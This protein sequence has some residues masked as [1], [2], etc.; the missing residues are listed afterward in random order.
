M[1]AEKSNTFFL[2]LFFILSLST[3]TLVAQN[4]SSLTLNASYVG[5][6]VANF[7]GGIKTGTTYLGL[8]NMK[9]A[10]D[11]EKA[12]WWKGGLF[13][14]NA[15]NTHGG[16]PTANLVGDYQAFSNIE[17]GNH[18]FM[19]ELWYKEQL[20]NFALTAG[21][22]DLNVDFAA[23]ESGILF[24]NSSF[25]IH[26]S[27]G[28]NIP[29]PIFPLTAL[30]VTLQWQLH[31]NLL[32]KVALFDGTPDEFTNNP[33]NLRW[34]LGRGDGYLGISEWQLSGSLLKGQEGTY[35]LGMY[36]HSHNDDITGKVN[37]YGF[38]LIGDQQIVKTGNGNVSLFSQIGVSPK[39]NVNNFFI[40]FGTNWKAPFATR[41]KDV[42][43]IAFAYA[44]MHD[45]GGIGGEVAIET[46]YKFHVNEHIYLRPDF[47][48]II[49]PAGTDKKLPNA[50]VG[51]MRF[52]IEF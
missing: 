51:T 50:F 39:K 19:Y 8:A 38:Y 17:A 43:G 12:G 29:S 24:S 22:Q 45:N 34:K 42:C 9:M 41:P 2:T 28:T 33:Y 14:V 11:L 25:G 48:Y 32:W 20:G 31:P 46:T 23:T 13:F 10:F 40:S 44:A 26:S 36:S 27:I 16:E 52:G 1:K 37:N 30:G 4:D 7:S 21:L 6:A 3:S 18:T 5:D 49:N 47:Q 35:K 15:G